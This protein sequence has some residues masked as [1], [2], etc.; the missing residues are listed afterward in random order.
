M[1]NKPILVLD[2]I[3]KSFAWFAVLFVILVLL[4]HF[5][6]GYLSVN[7]TPSIATGIYWVMP[8]VMPRKGDDAVIEYKGQYFER[9]VHLVKHVV[10]INGDLIAHNGNQVMINGKATTAMIKPVTLR[11]EPLLPGPVGCVPD[12]EFF[13]L[14]DHVDSFDSRYGH[15]GFVK[16]EQIIGKAVRLL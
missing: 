3:A 4:K 12:G 13:V 10:A 8:K 15:L 1:P 14:G 16:P 2:L 11:G 9:G 6:I 5:N 7:K